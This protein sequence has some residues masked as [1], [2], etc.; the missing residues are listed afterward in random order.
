MAT[1]LF[2]DHKIV[3]RSLAS[4]SVEALPFPGLFIAPTD[5]EV[6]GLLLYIGTAPGATHAV[7]VNCAVTAVSQV[8]ASSLITPNPY[9]MWTTANVPTITG[10]AQ[11]NIVA[12]QNQTLVNPNPYNLNYPLPGQSPVT[13]YETAQSPT[14]GTFTAVTTPPLVTK[15]QMSALT[16]PDNTYVDYNGITTAASILHTGDLVSFVVSGSSLGSSA[17]LQMELVLN[18]R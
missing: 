9:N 3:E 5:Y 4:V 8:G 11:S 1:G 15:F 7:S 13:G 12:V 17:N 18:K 2:Q 14:T 16:P 6:V 10:T